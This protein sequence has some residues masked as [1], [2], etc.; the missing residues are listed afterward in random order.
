MD[1]PL[2]EVL[3]EE[4]IDMIHQASM[5]L[6]RDNGML[7]LDHP[8]A[9]ETLRKNGARVDGQMVR[10]DEDTLMN[11]VEQAPSTFTQLARNPAN[12][13]PIGGRNMI[14]A[15]VYGPA[16][17]TDLDRGRRPSTLADF[18]DLAKLVYMIPELHHAGGVL[19][20]PNDIP[21]DERHLDMIMAHINL[22]D[23]AFMGSTIHPDNAR[24]TVTMSEILFGAEA[25]RQDPAVLSII[26][27]SSP[28]RMDER[29]LSALEVYAAAGQA[30]IMASFIIVGAMSPV[31]LAAT[32]A[33][34]N[35]E[36]LFAIGYA[37]MINPGT[38]CIQ[39][40]FLPSVDMKTGAPCFGTAES[41]LALYACAQ[42][43]RRYNLPFRSGGNYAA[44]Q[45]PDAQAGYESASSIW[46]TVQAGTNFV[47]H[48]AGW[49]EGGLT[50]GF[51]KLILDAEMLGVMSK[52]VEGIGLSEE[53][54][55]W[56]AFE[57][58]G[59]GNH[60][61]GTAHTLRHFETAL[62]QHKVFTT[63]SHEKWVEDGSQ[64]AYKRANRIWKQMLKDYEPP[65]L[66]D[67]ISEELATFVAHRRA[68]IQA[69]RPRSDW[70][71][72]RQ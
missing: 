20:E 3:S 53:D 40:P 52:F 15:P 31:T 5:R 58:A 29:M 56:D 62:Y 57:E 46:P 17:S 27:V 55:A 47:L 68:E 23:R 71:S 48:A 41:A 16:F 61:L 67:A 34:Q 18:H 10:I 63:D 7:L 39:G 44:A 42:L 19:V 64:D 30:M 4:G 70:R 33:Q 66:D 9:L 24:D 14:F 22:S 69:G 21:V 28:M 32:I 12:H 35:A 37:Q 11:F 54:F 1:L 51:E 45:I 2:T 60:F 6:L 26:S 59:P 25:I 36:S 72:S 65:R 13:V 8:P 50:T 49:L 43:A 38:P